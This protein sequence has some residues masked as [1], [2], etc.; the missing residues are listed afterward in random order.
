MCCVNMRRKK[1]HEPQIDPAEIERLKALIAKEEELETEMKQDLKEAI[2]N[3]D[4]KLIRELHRLENRN[5]HL[6]MWIGVAVLMLVVVSFWVSKLDVIV[7]RP[8][9]NIDE[10]QNFDLGE[11]RANMQSTIQEVIKGIEDIKQQAKELEAET[12]QAT[13]SEKLF[14]GETKL[15]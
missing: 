9:N 14:N 11:A 8:F 7:N 3:Q 1:N 10:T 4:K 12:N 5:R 15:P 13:S 2:K 6:I